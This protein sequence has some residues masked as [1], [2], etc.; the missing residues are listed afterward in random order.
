MDDPII[1]AVGG[2]YAPA[3]GPLV[4][5]VRFLDPNCG[6]FF[7]IEARFVEPFLIQTRKAAAAALSEAAKLSLEPEQ[8][9]QLIRGRPEGRA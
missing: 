6:E 7:T 3:E 5:V 4:P 8:A 1:R 9:R 2:V